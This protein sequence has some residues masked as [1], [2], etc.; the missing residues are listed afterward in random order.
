V[1]PIPLSARDDPFVAELLAKL[2]PGS[3][4]SFS[5]QQLVALKAALAGRSWGAHALDL[6]WTVSFWRRHYYFV[7]LT[8]RNRRMLT[9]AEEDLARN[10][11]ALALAGFLV[12][13]TLCGILVLY[14]IKSA[15]GIDIIPGFSFGVWGWFKRTFA[16]G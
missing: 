11:R 4:A 1:S 9:R 2:P 15:L 5:D 10:V 13:S 14:L 12:F 6:R 16:G 7:F 8:G 3:G